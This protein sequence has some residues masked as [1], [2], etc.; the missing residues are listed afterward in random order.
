M[1][2]AIKNIHG[3]GRQRIMKTVDDDCDIHFLCMVSTQW[4][5]GS[6]VSTRGFV[7]QWLSI[8]W[9]TSLARAQVV[10]AV[11]AIP[12]WFSKITRCT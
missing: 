4:F 7:V 9:R 8:P 3:T 11:F 1:N 5:C 2:L 6:V 12:K 10:S